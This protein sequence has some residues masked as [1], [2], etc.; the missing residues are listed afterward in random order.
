MQTRTV[1]VEIPVPEPT[2]LETLLWGLVAVTIAADAITTHA[3]LAAGH[4]E[5][6]PVAR[7]AIEGYGLA[8]FA[9]LKAGAVAVGL[10]CRPILPAAYRPIIPAGLAIPWL[11]A[12]A[13]NVAVLSGVVA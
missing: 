4:A 11:V 7:S 9:G 5:G 10:V 3:G 6:N 8:G 2:A 12:T 13:V 1:T